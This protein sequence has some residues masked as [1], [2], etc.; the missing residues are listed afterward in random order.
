MRELRKIKNGIDNLLLG[1]SITLLVAMVVI[2]IYQVFSRELLN[3]TPSWSEELSRVLFVWVSFLGIAYGF[4]EKL[5]IAVGL[6]IDALPKNVQHIFGY[7]TKFLII[8]F[9][10]VLMIY[11][12][13]FMVLMGQSYLPGLGVPS[14]VLYAVVPLSGLFIT[15]NGIDLLFEKETHQEENDASKG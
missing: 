14:S 8:G 11:G 10:I 9:G 13:K 3:F 15:V 2:I 1:L 6:V 5:H 4:K 7:L 12:W